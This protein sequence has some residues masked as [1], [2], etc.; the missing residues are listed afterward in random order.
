[1]IKDS[2]FATIFSDGSSRGNPGP[3]G[4]GAIVVL[5][6]NDKN[7]QDPIFNIPKET[8]VIELGGR[9][10]NTTNN[11]ME[12][13][14]ALE[15]VRLAESLGSRHALVHTD[16][17][18]VVNS[19]TKWIHGWVKNDW[20]TKDG[21]SISN[22]DLMECFYDMFSLIKI[23]FKQIAGHSGVAGNERCDEIATSFADNVSIDLFDGKLKDYTVSLSLEHGHK[24]KLS[25]SNSKKA[26]SYI[27]EIDGDIKIHKTW[28]E[29]KKRVEGKRARFK[30]SV[31][32]EDEERI[33]KEFS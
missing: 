4:W 15:A 23:E 3:G 1:M 21:K 13:T 22:R 17:S 11:R 26:F 33:V 5:N 20:Q 12:L 25:K 28:E 32:K 2:K 9:E 24:K 16:S 8:R 27:S 30:K 31:S 10:N 29:C 18:Y 19:L 6:E 14:G 7:F